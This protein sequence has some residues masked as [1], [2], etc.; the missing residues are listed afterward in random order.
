MARSVTPPT[1]LRV[2]DGNRELVIAASRSQPG[3][4]YVLRPLADGR[5]VCQCIGYAI[6]GRCAHTDALEVR[7]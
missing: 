5:L 6:R 3:S 2:R 4:G 7:E 1:I